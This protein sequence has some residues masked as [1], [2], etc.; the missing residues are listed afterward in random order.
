VKCGKRKKKNAPNPKKRKTSTNRDEKYNYDTSDEEDMHQKSSPPKQTKQ[1]N[2][3][4]DEFDDL[5]VMLALYRDHNKKPVERWDHTGFHELYGPEATLEIKPSTSSTTQS[6]Q[7]VHSTKNYGSDNESDSSGKKRKRNKHRHKKKK[8]KKSKKH[9]KDAPEE[10]E[11][12][13]SKSE[14][15]APAEEPAP[16]PENESKKSKKR[17]SVNEEVTT[18]EKKQSEEI[19]PE[20]HSANNWEKADL[21]DDHRKLKFLKLMGATKHKD[22]GEEPAHKH[23]RTSLDNKKIDQALEKQF[24]ES[25]N[26]KITKPVHVGLGFSGSSRPLQNSRKTF[27]DDDEAIPAE[28]AKKP[29]PAATAVNS[30]AES[31]LKFKKMSFVKSSS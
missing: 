14:V 30:V 12:K 5:K 4:S 11:I 19:I 21:G 9:S 27:D 6:S 25:L 18:E 13:K 15:V 8:S 26:S 2:E 31:K 20:V 29:E 17:K 24:T 16:S 1:T 7:K 22:N 23:T 28:D 3:D 10:T